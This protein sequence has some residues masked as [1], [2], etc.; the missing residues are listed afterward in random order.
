MM[1]EIATS[2]TTIQPPKPTPKGQPMSDEPSQTAT[3]TAPSAEHNL[4][5]CRRWIDRFNERDEQGEA[6]ARTPDYVAHAPAS[7]S[8]AP[9]DSEAWPEF[10]AGFVEGFPDLHLTV[11][12]AVGDDERVAQRIRFQGTHTG[13]FQGLPPTNRKI[14]VYVIELNRMA[15]GRVA[16]HWFQLDQVTLLQQLGLRVIPGPRLLPRLLAH[17]AMKLVRRPGRPTT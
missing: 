14:N 10:I 4:A 6:D 16:E 5:T 13:V 9:L 7:L 15:G 17:E 1:S 8:P 2:S 12:D 3:A 11:E